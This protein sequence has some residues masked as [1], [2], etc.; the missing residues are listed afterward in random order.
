MVRRVASITRDCG[1]IAVV[2]ADIR[3]A[4]QNE[5]PPAMSV[6]RADLREYAACNRRDGQF[7]SNAGSKAAALSDSLAAERPHLARCDPM[8]PDAPRIRA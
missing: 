1:A 3:V 5:R 4:L 6:Q 8:A 7:G 2:D